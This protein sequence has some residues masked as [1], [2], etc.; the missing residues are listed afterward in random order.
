[1]RL[2]RLAFL[3]AVT[4]AIVA[5]LAAV[6]CSSGGGGSTT[7]TGSGGATGSGT[8][9]ITVTGSSSVPTDCGLHSGAPACDQCLKGLHPGCCDVAQACVA[10]AGCVDYIACASQENLAATCPTAGQAE[11]EELFT[12]LADA[13]AAVCGVDP[14]LAG[15]PGGVG[16]AC[17]NDAHCTSGFCSALGHCSAFCAG[18]DDCAPLPSLSGA[19]KNLCAVTAS[20]ERQCFVGC[21]AQADC[22]AVAPHLACR[23]VGGAKACTAAQDTATPPAC[24]PLSDTARCEAAADCACGQA[25]MDTQGG[26]APVTTCAYACQSDADCVTASHGIYT[27]CLTGNG[28]RHCG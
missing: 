20:G 9:S 25:C 23:D 3:A 26:S 17:L 5:Q 27:V 6:G 19:N 28:V 7:T 18:D 16:S 8:T 11:A 22:D 13:C 21:A 2:P 1:M 10:T 12:C 4:S 24:Q 14:D 15:I